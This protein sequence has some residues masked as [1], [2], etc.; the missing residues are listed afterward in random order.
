MASEIG[1]PTPLD[2]ALALLEGSPTLSLGDV[3]RQLKDIYLQIES[4]DK[5]NDNATS[6]SKVT[7]YYSSTKTEGKLGKSGIRPHAVSGR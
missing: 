5:V 2:R 7:R 3:Q 4:E 1:T 6:A